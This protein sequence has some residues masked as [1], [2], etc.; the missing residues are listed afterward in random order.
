LAD[1][2]DEATGQLR[3][4]HAAWREADAEPEALWTLAAWVLDLVLDNAN[5]PS[6]QI[7]SQSRAVK[8]F[9]DRIDA[10]VA[11]GVR[12]G[13]RSVLVA[14]LSHISEL[15]PK[16]EL[17]GSGCNANLTED[18]MDALW[19]RARVALDSL[20]SHVPSSVAAALLTARESSGSGIFCR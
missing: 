2:F 1:H 8:L 15:N 16:S 10:T 11:N 7:A 13:T 17:L 6:C 4:E 3:A 9:E 5:E 12:W 20:V 14:A 19:T 18:Q